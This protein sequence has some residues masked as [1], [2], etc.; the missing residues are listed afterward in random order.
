M[1][2]DLR[3]AAAPVMSVA[4]RKVPRHDTP[5]PT[6]DVPDGWQDLLRSRLDGW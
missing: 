5:E 4:A 6:A 3:P 1:T 2:L